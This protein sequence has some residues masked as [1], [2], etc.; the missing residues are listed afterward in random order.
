MA[1]WMKTAGQ[2]PVQFQKLT[3]PITENGQAVSGKCLFNGI[4]VKTDGSHD[5]TVNA[6]DNDEASGTQL[7]PDD[8]VFP[9]TSRI[10]SVSM[11]PGIFCANGIYIKVSGT[12]GA[13]QVFYDD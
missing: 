13:L 12:G 6:Y 7:F 3:V 5:I 4:M 9:G 8:I 2:A 11:S 1:M 10:A